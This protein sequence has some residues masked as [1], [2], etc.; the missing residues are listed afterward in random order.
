MSNPILASAVVEEEIPSLVRPEV[1]SEPVSLSRAMASEWI[2][3]RTLRSSWAILIAAVIGLPAIGL[4][5]AYNTR[6]I[7]PS[8]APEDLGPS[9]TMQGFLLGQLLIGALGVLVVSGEYSTGMIRSTFAA[10]PK[11]LPTVWAKALVFAVVVGT[12]LTVAAVV[13]FLSSQALLSHYR[14][15]YSLA[16]PGVPRAV[17]GTAMYLTLLGVLGGAVGWIVRNTPG[18]LV[19]FLGL[20]L[21]VPVI[22]GNLLGNWGKDVA[23]FMPGEAGRSF[24][25][26]LHQP[27]MLSVGTGLVVFLAWVAVAVACATVLLRRRDV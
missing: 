5:V 15:G 19:S 20:I 9:A 13:A 3:F 21:V 10:V 8:I 27:Y 22:F 14:P 26:G 12:T 2:K 4:I 6:H 11:R 18:A 17:F 25:T 23:Q 1:H 7:S 24:I 16:D